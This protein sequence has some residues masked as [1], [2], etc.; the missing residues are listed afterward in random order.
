MFYELVSFLSVS[1]LSGGKGKKG[2]N[3]NSQ[4]Q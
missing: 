3:F 2:E 1:I 4:I